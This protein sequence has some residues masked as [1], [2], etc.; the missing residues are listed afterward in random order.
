[1]KKI[2][3]ILKTKKSKKKGNFKS[4]IKICRGGNKWILM[5]VVWLVAILNI[6]VRPTGMIFG[7][8]NSR[9]KVH[10]GW[11]E[12][13]PL[14]NNWSLKNVHSTESHQINMIPV[15]LKTPTTMYTWYWERKKR[16]KQIKNNQ[17]K[18]E[19]HLIHL[20]LEP[21]KFPLG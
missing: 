13:G 7:K 4:G 12:D 19:K 3:K 18:Q 8:M 16:N 1:M 11:K 6:T 2:N 15:W 9:S 20:P 14:P 5:K 10:E 17:W 21:G